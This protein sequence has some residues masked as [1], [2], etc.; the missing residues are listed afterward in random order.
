MPYKDPEK[1]RAAYRRW[2]SRN[3]E[4]VRSYNKILYIAK[5]ANP[6]AQ[7]CSV[8]GCDQIGERHHPD[9]SKPKDIVWICRAHHRRVEH[10][11]KC[12]MCG[13]KILGRGLCNKHYKQERKKVDSEYKKKC[14]YWSRRKKVSLP[15]IKSSSFDKKNNVRYAVCSHNLYH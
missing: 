11:G 9:Y 13:D 3:T 8:P 7:P 14:L 6:V 1:R 10:A 15:P 4:K 5:R 2:V 12:S